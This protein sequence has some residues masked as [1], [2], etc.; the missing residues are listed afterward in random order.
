MILSTHQPQYI[1]WLGYFDKIAKSDCFVFLD[2]VQYK[3]RE[4]QNRNRIRSKNKW[5]WL[6]VPVV[7]KCQRGQRICDC[8]IDNTFPWA[9]KHLMSLKACYGKA[10]F[11]DDHFPFFEQ[12]YAQRWE[13]LADLNVHIINYIL[14]QLSLSKPIYFGSQLDTTKKK[15]GLIIEICQK[16][17]AD[18]YLSGIGGKDY[19]EEEKFE[20]ANI[21]LIYQDFT[22]PVYQQEFMKDKNDFIPYMS[23]LDLLFNE[24]P[25]SREILLNLPEGQ[26]GG[27]E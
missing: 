25:K 4:F 1:P 10:E 13:K 7:S 26:P 24:G 17:K 27:S 11:F 18:T 22:H 20:K 9:R 19:I 2:Q 16:L 14:K 12:V 8:A 6:S 3:H 5:I 23:V 21:K 15:T